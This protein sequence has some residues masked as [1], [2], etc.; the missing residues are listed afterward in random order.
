VPRKRDSPED[1]RASDPGATADARA[2][3]EGQPVWVDGRAATFV[4]LHPSGKAA[5]VR[6]AGEQAGRVIGLH[7]L[8]LR[9][10]RRR[11]G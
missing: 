1:E 2:L 9:P 8:Q 5:V 7:K 3:Q 4:Y 11:T 6:Y 10:G